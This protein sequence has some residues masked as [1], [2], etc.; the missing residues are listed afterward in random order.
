MPLLKSDDVDVYLLKW[1]G[2]HNILLSKKACYKGI[3]I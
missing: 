3:C 2:I 1:Q